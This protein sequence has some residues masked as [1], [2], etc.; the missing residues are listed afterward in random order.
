MLEEEEWAIKEFDENQRSRLAFIDLLAFRVYRSAERKT[1]MNE[2]TIRKLD[3]INNTPLWRRSLSTLRKYNQFL[4]QQTNNHT[5]CFCKI[6][7]LKEHIEEKIHIR[8]QRKES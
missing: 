4:R 3:R 7:A 5:N 1:I 2:Q 6:C 8:R